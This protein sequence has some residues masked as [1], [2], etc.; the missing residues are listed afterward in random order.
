MPEMHLRRVSG[1]HPH[2]ADLAL[3][4][5]AT[6]QGGRV[7]QIAHGWMA[8]AERRLDSRALERREVQRLRARGRFVHIVSEGDVLAEMMSAGLNQ[9]VVQSALRF[10]YAPRRD[11]FTAHMVR[12]ELRT[13]RG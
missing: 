5:R 2:V 12:Y 1:N 11:P 13:F 6:L 4:S 10:G 3:H 8:Q 9:V 7:E